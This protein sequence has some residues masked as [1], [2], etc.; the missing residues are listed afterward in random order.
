MSGVKPQH[1]WCGVSAR[2]VRSLNTITKRGKREGYYR[3]RI[4]WGI[5]HTKAVSQF[6]SNN[7][8]QNHSQFI[9]F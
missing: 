6:T 1:H 3:Y 4:S 5:T 7:Y 8:V 9:P 2:V